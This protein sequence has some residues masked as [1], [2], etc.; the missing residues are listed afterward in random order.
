[1]KRAFDVVFSLA[2]L[3]V[4][5]PLLSWISWRIWREDHGP[6]FYRGVRTGLKGKPFRIFKFRTMVVDAEK[7]GPSSTANEDQRITGVGKFL[8]K[9]KLDELPQL[10]NVFFGQMSFVGPRPEVKRFTDMYTE[11]EKAILTVRPGIT[12]WASIW[13]SDE[14]AILA[15]AQDPDRAYMELIRPTKIRLQLKYVQENSIA[16]DLKIIILTLLAMFRPEDA[17]AIAGVSNGPFIS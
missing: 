11:E 14:G 12:D 15:G 7:I 16:I 17:R 3:M 10:F 2:G 1:M 4:L 8:R 6:V 9:N 5:S 13:N